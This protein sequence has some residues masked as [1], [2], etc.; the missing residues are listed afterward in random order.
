MID[1]TK[2]LNISQEFIQNP[3]PSYSKMLSSNEPF[4]LPTSDQKGFD[5]IW[6]FSQYSQ[7]RFILKLDSDKISKQIEKIMPESVPTIL[8]G[9]MLN[10]DPPNHQRLR[11]LASE[12]FSPSMLKNIEPRIRSITQTLV[13]KIKKNNATDFITSVALP[14]PVG[15]IAYMMGVPDCDQSL[16]QGWAID[17]LKGI[18]SSN[19]SQKIIDKQKKSHDDLSRYFTNLISLKDKNPDDSI[20]SNLTQ[21]FN[22]KKICF[23][24]LIKMCIFLLIVGYETTTGLI[25]NGL[26][27]LLKYP[28]QLKLL[29][30]NPDLLENAI[31]EILRFESPFQRTSFRVTAN[32]CQI[33]NVIYNPGQL[34]GIVIGAANRD[35]LIFQDPNSFDIKR[36]NNKHIAFGL[37]IH[38]C[39]GSYLARLEAKICLDYLIKSFKNIELLEQPTW[40]STSVIRNLSALKIICN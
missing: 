12:A 35:P 3:Y 19:K 2:V 30:K 34:I 32:E 13:K 40:N 38:A 1:L 5:G 4:W 14:L 24:E 26:Y 8:D 37:G 25:G 36:T 27:C 16:V 11:K 22:N 39:L 7:A 29:R 18:D 17:I 23:D 6:L 33:G 31:E 28:D 15:I 10:T 20:C 21:A 9:T